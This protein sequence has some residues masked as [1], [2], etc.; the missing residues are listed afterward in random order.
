MRCTS[1]RQIH[2][3]AVR[4]DD[5]G[6][7]LTGAAGSG[8]SDL[9]LRLVDGGG[10]LVADDR[11]DLMVENGEL[12]VSCPP[13]IQN[14]LEV[15]GIGIVQ[16]DALASARVDLIVELCPPD[17]IERMPE[18]ITHDGYGVSL[19]VVKIAPFEAS[20]AAKIRIALDRAD[21]IMDTGSS[22]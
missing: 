16:M 8:K 19:P 21:H 10:R 11:C 6:I 15:R 18:N 4:V 7:L 2:A 14:L 5:S 9:A 17:R 3:T 13:E 20:A 22:L 12:I 1:V